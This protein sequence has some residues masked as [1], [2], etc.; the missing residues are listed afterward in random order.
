MYLVKMPEIIKPLASQFLWNMPRDERKVYL[1]FD[2]GPT[3]G[4]TDQILDILQEYNAKATFFCLGKQ[5]ELAPDLFE[6]LVQEGHRIGNHTYSHPNGWKTTAFAYLKNVLQA[7]HFIQTDL[8]RPPY[9]RITRGQATAI[10]KRYH[11][12]MWDIITGDFDLNTTPEECYERV[13]KHLEGGS[14]IVMHD[15]VKASK[16]VL[17]SVRPII[18]HI[19]SLGYELA[20]LPSAA[21]LEE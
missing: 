10:R 3:P 19:L 18:E 14:I 11:L 9:G 13:A 6:R 8:Y 21:S 17:G 20:P 16:N 5:V 12:V 4:I 7:E 1:T 15:S 2:D